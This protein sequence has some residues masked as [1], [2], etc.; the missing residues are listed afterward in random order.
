MGIGE[1]LRATK[2]RL[3]KRGRTS[4]PIKRERA[5][6][7]AEAD[8]LRM[9]YRRKG[10]GS[11]GGGARRT[12]AVLARRSADESAPRPRTVYTLT[13]KGREA[14]DVAELAARVDESARAAH[15]LPHRRPYL[16]LV[17]DFLRRLLDLHLEL[18]DE[19]ER[20]LAPGSRPSVS[21]R[22][23]PASPDDGTGWLVTA[24]T[25]GRLDVNRPYPPGRAKPPLTH[26]TN[27]VEH[28]PQGVESSGQGEGCACRAR[29]AG[30]SR[31]AVGPP[32]PA[33]RGPDRDGGMG[34]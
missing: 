7:K 31:A 12:I 17:H 20:E 14:L 15:E 8:A 24:T 23:R 29:P 19:V 33:S 34:G 18:V 13:P 26:G 6:R 11:S 25:E 21:G 5:Q 32:R 30:P 1:R 22:G 16:L 28:R 3:A 9:E 27:D 4:D 2:D 10:P